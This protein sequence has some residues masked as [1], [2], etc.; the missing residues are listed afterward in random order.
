MNYKR[1]FIEDYFSGL[2]I[3]DE[4]GHYTRYFNSVKF[5]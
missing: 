3:L 2:T 5:K 4:N 1:Y